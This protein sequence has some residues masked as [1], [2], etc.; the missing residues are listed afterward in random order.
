MPPYEVIMLLSISVVDLR[1]FE[2]EIFP[3]K[4]LFLSVS[5]NMTLPP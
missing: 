4:L 5:E 2:F 1:K 3:I